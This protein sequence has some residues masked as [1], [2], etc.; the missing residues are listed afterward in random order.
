[1]AL[2]IVA[3]RVRDIGTVYLFVIAGA[4][5]YSLIGKNLIYSFVTDSNS[6]LPLLVGI[7]SF[8]LFKNMNIKYK[9]HILI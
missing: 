5:V 8:M 1:M 7:S 2:H 6:V 4:Y 3:E 9:D